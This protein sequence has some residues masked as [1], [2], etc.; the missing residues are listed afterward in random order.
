MT[1][2][3]DVALPGGQRHPLA[4]IPQQVFDA[5]RAALR[6]MTIESRLSAGERL[7]DG[8]LEAI[9]DS[10][11]NAIRATGFFACGEPEAVEQLAEARL[12]LARLA[13]PKPLDPLAKPGR[14]LGPGR[15]PDLARELDYRREYA[16]RALAGDRTDRF[17]GSEN[18]INKEEGT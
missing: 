11:V 6:E 14:I 16:R 2:Y 18:N 15:V 8:E 10:M 5:A 4:G 17:A 13:S 12:A 3:D 7:L 1:R 9:A